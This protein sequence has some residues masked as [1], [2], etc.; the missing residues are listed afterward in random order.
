MDYHMPNG[1]LGPNQSLILYLIVYSVD[2]ETAARYIHNTPNKNKNT[3]IVVVSAYSGQEANPNNP[4]F[5]ASLMKP[6]QKSDL[7]GVM[8]QLGFKSKCRT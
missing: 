2:G 5:A 4:V 1:Q 6:V 3:P 7:I 8:R